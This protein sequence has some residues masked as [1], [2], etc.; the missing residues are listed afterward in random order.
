M[1]S[2]ASCSSFQMN[3]IENF[4]VKIASR[5]SGT[6][7]IVSAKCLFCEKF[8]KEEEEGDDE[9]VES[10]S[11]RKRRRT[12]NIKYFKK[13]WRSDNIA[14]HMKKQH[15]LKF[16]EYSALSKEEKKTFFLSNDTTFMPL[17][18]VNESIL[19]LVNK[20]I[21]ETIIGTMLIDPDDDDEN[22]NN[23]ETALQDFQL[24][25]DDDDGNVERYLISFDNALQFRLILSYIAA[26]LSFRQCV[27]VCQ[28]TKE[29]T[30]L[31]QIGNVSMAKVIRSTRYIC[32][33]SYQMISDIL[34]KV[35]AFSIAFDGGNKSNTSYFD[36]R[37]RFTME[38][39]LHNK[40]L[41][42]LP[43]RERHTGEYM[44]RLMFEFLDALYPGW[45]SKLIGI[46]SDGASNMTGSISGVVTRLCGVSLR[47]CY[48]VWCCAHQLDLVVQKSFSHL[49][50]D[51]FIFQVTAVTGHLRRQQNLISD[52]KSKCP[53]F[54]DTRWLSMEKFLNW[55]VKNRPRLFIH[56]EDKKPSCAPSDSWY[57]VVYALN[58]FL[59]PINRCLVSIQGLTTLL[60]EQ[61]QQLE[62]LIRIL[63][64][65]GFVDGPR[66]DFQQEND[67]I[68][69]GSYRVTYANARKFLE[70]QDP[71]AVNL[72]DKL[73]TEDNEEYKSVL[74]TIAKLFAETVDGFS[75]IVAERNESNKP[76]DLL[77]P[78]LP[79]ELLKLRSFN[80]SQLLNLHDDRL[81]VTFS[82]D[83]IVT[84]FNEFKSMK[85]AYRRELALKETLD[86][87][88][89]KS[90]NKAWRPL[91]D[92]FPLLC[93]FS[94]G[95]ASV[96]P[97]TSTVESDFSVIG[98][99]KND[100]RTCLTDFS[101]EGILHA[102]QYLSLKSIV[103]SL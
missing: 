13:P 10:S 60:S 87:A 17:N 103:G 94:G 15:K 52:M 4:G 54:I 36:V 74:E 8:G 93:K 59:D 47:G 95:L 86:Q 11:A 98:W 9:A 84:I 64:E 57:I 71:F 19:M 14:S 29:A 44:F 53:R 56:F 92:R 58:A 31:G 33:M 45:K 101:L 91:C 46:S 12:D 77:P 66:N 48:R 34:H 26:G 2:K 40:H 1:P 3:W 39:N 27:N 63:I 24:Q 90:F 68:I 50:N 7:S 88:D 51:T 32:A 42:A 30:A 62:E 89:A 80:F 81:K 25:E 70:E 37:I 18:A 79:L 21:V 100:Y 20:S 69:N 41:V 65:D 5:D 99:E 83:E 23:R 82:E 6:S 49:C 78:V 67:S 43:M 28:G 102:K 75:K 97:G 38:N 35:W 76:T 85:D 16:A 55:I 61:Q 22:I 72:L 73:E 96:F